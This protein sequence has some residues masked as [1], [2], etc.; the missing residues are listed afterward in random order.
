MTDYLSYWAAGKLTLAGDPAA[1]YDPAKHRAVE[2]TVT[3]FDKFMPFPYP[4]PFLLLVTPFSLLPYIWSFAAWVGLTLAIY[5]FAAR[6]A[7]DTPYALANPLVLMNG[8]IGQNGFLTAA[9]FTTGAAMLRE[10]PLVAGAVLGVL[11]IKP[12][13]ALLLPVAVIAGR[14]WPAIAG[15]I[16]MAGA[17]TFLSL[18]FLGSEAFGGFWNILHLYVELLRQDKWS[19]NEFISVFAFL[20]YL[21]VDPSVALSLH[22]IIAAAATVLTWIAWSRD[23][24]EQVPI[25]AAAT[26]LIPPYLLSYDALLM[27]IPIGFFLRQQPR[28]RLA[29][30]LWLLCLLPI[31]FHFNLY[32]GPN[33]I[34]IAAILT[35]AILARARA[36]ISKQSVHR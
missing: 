32:R 7:I 1:A 29:G 28:P 14:L 18:A 4:P 21:D 30:A 12:Q 22:A 11:I 10:R 31:A 13:L 17:L 34:P 8:A 23:W 16:A 26:L 2:F 36:S 24:D 27:I 9:I 35:L 33:T 19:W 6:R 3:T 25:L 20:R 15:A 5:L